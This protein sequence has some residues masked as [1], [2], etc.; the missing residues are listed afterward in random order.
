M[1]YKKY[2]AKALKPTADRNRKKQQK[3][4][5]L[6]VV[7]KLRSLYTRSY[8]ECTSSAGSAVDNAIN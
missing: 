3:Q 5:T 8:A 2:Q 6:I 4:Y 7:I 1:Y